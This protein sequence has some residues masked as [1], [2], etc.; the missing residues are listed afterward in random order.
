MDRH[1]NTANAASF[2]INVM[3]AVNTFKLPAIFLKNFAEIFARDILHTITSRILSCL[4]RIVPSRST[5][6][7]P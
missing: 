6:K 3:T 2:H 1:T 5:L 7:Q 4:E